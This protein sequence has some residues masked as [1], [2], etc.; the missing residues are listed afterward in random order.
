GKLV[1][2]RLRFDDRIGNAAS[3]EQRRNENEKSTSEA[4]EHT[5]KRE[6]IGWLVHRVEGNNQAPEAA[7]N[8][9]D[10]EGLVEGGIEWHIR[11]QAEFFAQRTD[12]LGPH[13]CRVLLKHHRRIG[14]DRDP[15]SNPH[16]RFQLTWPP[17]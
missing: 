13:T 7:S 14:R 15:R 9:R 4:D 16:F 3:G 1:E 10:V 5:T 8:A 2:L 17:A 11:I 12:N 6:I